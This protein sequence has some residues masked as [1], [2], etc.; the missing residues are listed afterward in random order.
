MDR[1]LSPVPKLRKMFVQQMGKHDFVEKSRGKITQ[2][3]LTKSYKH[4][5]IEHILDKVEYNSYYVVFFDHVCGFYED[6]CN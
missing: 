5:H 3:N 4:K 1:V 2:D 6:H